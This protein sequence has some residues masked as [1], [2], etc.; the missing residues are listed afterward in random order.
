MIELLKL[1]FCTSLLVL[2]WVIATQENMV[3]HFIRVWAEGL[4]TK[5][6]E[7]FF[8]CVW[9]Q[10]SVWSILGYL[11][12]IATGMVNFSFQNVYKYPLVVCGSSLLCGLIWTVYLTMNAAKEFFESKTFIEEDNE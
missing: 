3:L 11:M 5:W 1:I 8:L 7:P 4:K 2:G 6:K 9:C 10:P 12:A